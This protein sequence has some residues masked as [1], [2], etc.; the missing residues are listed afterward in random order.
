MQRIG[1][2]LAAL[3]HLRDDG[4]RGLHAPAHCLEDLLQVGERELDA[5]HLERRVYLPTE[6]IVIFK[7]RVSDHF[8]QLGGHSYQVSITAPGLRVEQLFL[9]FFW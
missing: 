8:A 3:V 7:H 9:L 4:R 5:D 2:G 1:L 6:Q